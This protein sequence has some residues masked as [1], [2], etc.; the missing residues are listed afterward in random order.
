MSKRKIDPRI[1]ERLIYRQEALS[2]EDLGLPDNPACSLR[3]GGRFVKIKEEEGDFHPLGAKGV[4]VGAEISGRQ[5]L[6]FI[7]FDDSKVKVN[8][9]DFTIIGIMGYMIKRDN[10][11]PKK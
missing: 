4:V 10:V 7:M 9:T 5:E 2:V 8:D 3:K 6:Y 1:K 11:I